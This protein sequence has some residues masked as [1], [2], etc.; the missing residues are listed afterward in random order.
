MLVLFEGGIWL[1]DESGDRW[2]VVAERD[3]GKYRKMDSDELW[4]R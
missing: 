2:V 4:L 3:P 1:R